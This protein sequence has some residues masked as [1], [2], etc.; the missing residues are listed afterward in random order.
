MNTINRTGSDVPG[1]D[2]PV[3]HHVALHAARIYPATGHADDGQPGYLTMADGT[4][5]AVGP[6]PEPG[7]TVLELGDVDLIPGLVDLHSDCWDQRARPRS[8][9]S[10]PLEDALIVLD[11]EATSWGITTHYACIAIQ[12]D[13]TKSRTL[14]QALA[15]VDAMRTRKAHLRADHRIHLRV[16]LTT[17]HLDIIRRLVEA[18]DVSLMS[19]LDHTPGQ[20]QFKREADWRA[21]LSHRGAQNLDQAL[22]KRYA[23]R[24][25]VAAIRDE[26]AALARTHGITLASHDDDTSEDVRQA[27]ELGARIVE[28]PVTEDA[29]AAAQA[30]GLATVMGA[31]NLL[32]GSSQTAGNLS[33]REALNAGL[34]NIVAS[35]YY[36]PAL[37]RCVYKIVGEGIAAQADAIRLVTANPARA[38]GLTDRG[39]LEPGKR[40]DVVAVRQLQGQPVVAQTWIAGQPAFGARP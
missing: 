3:T 21:A 38:A 15:A 35:D 13:I 6:Q 11:T 33:A 8:T 29:A 31:P 28:F 26:L 5:T 1:A 25:Y 39:T 19:Y 7:A 18:G 4:I 16:D 34:L 10:F 30:Q 17:E 22:A 40:A 23:R 36:P 2:R 14:D 32:R 37:L 20:G 12:D 27:R 9:Y 24:P